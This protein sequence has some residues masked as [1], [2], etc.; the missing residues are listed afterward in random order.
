MGSLTIPVLFL[1]ADWTTIFV[2]KRGRTNER[3]SQAS[4]LVSFKNSCTNLSLANLDFV[5]EAHRKNGDHFYHIGVLL[6][7]FPLFV[8]TL[9]EQVSKR[10]S[11]N[12]SAETWIVP[13]VPLIADVR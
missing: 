13:L 9:S 12:R 1:T 11:I 4:K 7:D 6:S 2:V 5:L 8:K 3:E 10:G